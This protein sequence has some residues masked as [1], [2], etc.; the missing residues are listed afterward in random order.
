MEQRITIDYNQI[1]GLIHQL[2]KGEIEK[3]AITLQAEISSKKSS[4]SII[5]KILNAP[6]W[7]DSDFNDYQ[8]ARSLI[9]KSRIA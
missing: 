2:P 3:I 5:E 1:L 8:E 9:N 7:S 4:I 6:T